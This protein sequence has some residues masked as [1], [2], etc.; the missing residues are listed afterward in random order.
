[1]RALDRNDDATQV[2]S[3][4]SSVDTSLMR[5]GGYTV[6]QPQGTWGVVDLHHLL[7]HRPSAEFPVASPPPC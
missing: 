7:C 2:L 1:M 5:V 3:F 4:A 6:Y